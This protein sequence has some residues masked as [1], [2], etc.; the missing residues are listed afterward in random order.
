MTRSL[1]RLL[2]KITECVEPQIIYYVIFKSTPSLALEEKGLK[3]TDHEEKDS[4]NYYAHLIAPVRY[5]K[6][7]EAA[8]KL[9]YAEITALSNKHGYCWS[10][11]KYF[12]E[13]YDVDTRTIQRWMQSLKD[14]GFIVIELQTEGIQTKRKIWIT[15]TIKYNLTERQNCH[16][17]T[18]KLSPPPGK[19]VVPNTKPNTKPKKLLTRKEEATPQEVVFPCL[20]QLKLSASK[21]RQLS[22]KHSEEI[23]IDAVKK[24]MAWKGK[25]SHEAAIE[26]I[27]SRAGDWNQ[28]PDKEDII[29]KNKEYLKGLEKNDGKKLGKYRCIVA[30]QTI[31][32]ISEGMGAIPKIFD[33]K[34]LDFVDQVNEFI[35]QNK[36]R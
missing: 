22:K 13:L 31:E 12:A 16:P 11:N 14:E 9:L 17:P 20:D 29:E 4:P 33:V 26:T 23:L 8:A 6:K 27:L 1:P 18:T 2:S 7:L 34:Q 21:K 24:A 36:P 10:S 25:K 28:A 19:N 35:K 30:Y 32:F 5:S 3:M 15:E